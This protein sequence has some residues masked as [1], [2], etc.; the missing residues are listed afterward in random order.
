MICKQLNI[1]KLL[2]NII[3]KVTLHAKFFKF[4]N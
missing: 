4:K 1:V 2:R 3:F